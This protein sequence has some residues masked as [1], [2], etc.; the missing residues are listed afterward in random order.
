MKRKPVVTG[1]GSASWAGIDP[2][3]AVVAL[4]PLGTIQPDWILALDWQYPAVVYS[5]HLLQD[6]NRQANTPPLPIAACDHR[7]RWW[8]PCSHYVATKSNFL[9]A[10]L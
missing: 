4:L 10:T 2:G 8:L 3:V 7:R 5:I 9:N 6:V 1:H